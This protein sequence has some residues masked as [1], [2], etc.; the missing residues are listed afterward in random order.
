MDYEF[1]STYVL[2]PEC[3]TARV[4]QTIKATIACRKSRICGMSLFLSRGVSLRCDRGRRNTAQNSLRH[5]NDGLQGRLKSTTTAERRPPSSRTSVLDIWQHESHAM[6]SGIL[7]S[8][9]VD[10]LTELI[11]HVDHICQCEIKYNNT[12]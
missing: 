5:R 12:I 7:V 4:E 10:A 2:K 9:D 1:L 8:E 3:T 6:G 11:F